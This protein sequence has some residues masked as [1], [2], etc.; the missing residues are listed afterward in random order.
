MSPQPV[1]VPRQ[2]QR[3][4]EFVDAPERVYRLLALAYHLHPCFYCGARTDCFHRQPELE[5]ALILKGFTGDL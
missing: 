3:D 4:P 2:L 1:L 5:L